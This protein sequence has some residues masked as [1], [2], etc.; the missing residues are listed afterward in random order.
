ME[1]NE[2]S[3]FMFLLGQK[4]LQNDEL[5]LYED[6]A[7]TM[8]EIHVENKSKLIDYHLQSVHTRKLPALNSYLIEE[9]YKSNRD[10]KH[11]S[12]INDYLN[13]AR[14]L[15]PTELNPKL[16]VYLS[17]QWLMLSVPR[18]VDHHSWIPAYNLFTIAISLKLYH[19]SFPIWNLLNCSNVKHLKTTMKFIECCLARSKDEE[20]LDIFYKLLASMV[21][22]KN[23][24][25][26]FRQPRIHKDFMELAKRYNRIDVF[27]RHY[28]VY[29]MLYPKSSY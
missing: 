5:K 16:I 7:I 29:K 28:K 18:Q 9:C 19:I 21:I 1:R 3:K 26:K 23:G 10:I 14:T 25:Y 15:F 4:Y 17:K 22:D 20:A 2:F 27:K 11:L 12:A 24:W 6:L 13:Y 8:I